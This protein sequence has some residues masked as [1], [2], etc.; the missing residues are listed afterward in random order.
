MVGCL[1]YGLGS[2]E[3]TDGYGHYA[4]GRSV[5]FLPAALE[6]QVAPPSPIGRAILWT[7]MA[8][9]AVSVVWASV[10]Q[11]DIVATAQGK[12]IPSG[13]SKVVQPYETGVIAAIRVQDG[14]VVKQG[15]VLIELDPTQNQ[16]DRDRAS[17]EYRATKVEA[18]RLQ[19]LVAGATTFVAPSDSDPQ[20]VRL[21]QQLLRDQLAEYQARVDAAQYIITQRMAAI[22]A[23]RENVQRLSATV[24]METERATAFKRLM[25]QDAVT[26]L[27]YLQA[28]GQRIDKLQELAGQQHK[29]RQD[30]AALAEAEKN[31][32]ALI[33]EFQ[34]TKQTELSALE[35]K[36]ASISQDVT[37]ARQKAELQRLSSPIDGVVQQLAVH[38]VGGVVTPAQ[39]LLIVVP[40]DHPVEVE[41]QLENKDVG[42]VKE[43]QSAEIKIE[44]FPFTLYGTIPGTVLTVSDDAVPIDKNKPADGLV[45][46]TRVSLASGTILV[47]GK[48]VHLSPGMVV[49]V[50]IKTGR[51]R[52]I[53][54]LLSPVLKSLQESLRE[55]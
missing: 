52:L 6:I 30:Q 47:E 24:P 20:Y 21:Q 1:V 4:S 5:E 49:T 18:A 8:L 48:S 42:F 26:K 14:Q 45:F 22:D 28:E 27:D 54:Y 43:G 25:E 37:K 15:E 55:R 11:I 31:R 16:A 7:I 3:T 50:E 32:R 17:N 34:Q 36:A 12:I 29:L 10:G 53:E 23:T 38:T 44:T 40:Q 41:A 13:Y 35:T 51:R 19:A 33:S 46:A 39:P 9:L 2:G